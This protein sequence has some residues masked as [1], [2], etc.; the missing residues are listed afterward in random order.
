LGDPEDIEASQIESAWVFT[1][2][3]S[4]GGPGAALVGVTSIVEGCLLVDDAVVVWPLSD[5]ERAAAAI[6]GAREEQSSVL[7]IGGMVL[8]EANGG[9]DGMPT[10]PG[11]IRDHCASGFTRVWMASKN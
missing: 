11:V 7:T 3:G 2:E 5:R 10:I 6:R 1:V 4:E 9:A 8:V